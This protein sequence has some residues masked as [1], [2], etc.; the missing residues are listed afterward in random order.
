MMSTKEQLRARY[1]FFVA[2]AAVVFSKNNSGQKP[3]NCESFYYKNKTLLA[4]R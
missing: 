2:V 1:L 4:P 3:Q